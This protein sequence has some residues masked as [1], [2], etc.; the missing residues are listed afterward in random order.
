VFSGFPGAPRSARQVQASSRLFFDVFRQY[1][2]GNLLLAQAEAETLA[3]ELD[4]ERMQRCLQRLARCEVVMRR[5]ER[6]SP[7]AFP[8]LVERLRERLSTEQLSERVR[9]LVAEMEAALEVGPAR[10]Q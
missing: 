2:P 4:F 5:T 6:F 10:P 8:L 7:F 9:R 3:Q 1:D